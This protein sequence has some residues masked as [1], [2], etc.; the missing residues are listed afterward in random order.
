[1]IDVR[2]LWRSG[3][4]SGGDVAAHCQNC[5]AWRGGLPGGLCLIHTG[6]LHTRIVAH[7]FGWCKGGCPQLHIMSQASI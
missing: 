2:G 6:R 3:H 5:Q 4:A 1:M 7:D